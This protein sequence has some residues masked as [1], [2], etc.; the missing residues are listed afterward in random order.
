LP[1]YGES[2]PSVSLTDLV[3]LTLQASIVL[4][5]FGLGLR[6]THQDVTCLFRRPGMLARSLLPMFVVMPIL[7]AL[8]AGMFGLRPPVKIALVALSVSPVPPL[9]PRRTMRAGGEPSYTFGLLVAA[10]LLSIVLL[11]VEL[12]S[13]GLAFGVPL[14]APAAAMIK[15]VSVTVIAPLGGGILARSLAPQL[16]ARIAK[17]ILLVAMVML[18]GGMIPVLLKAGPAIVSLVGNGTLAAIAAFIVAG[19]IAGHLLG[20]PAPEHRTVLALATAFRHPGIAVAIAESNFP[21]QKLV[22]AAVLL[23]LLVGAVLA[24]PYVASRRR[25][26]GRQINSRIVA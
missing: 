21:E 9:L 4:N 13:I 16:V 5:V 17:P 6:A 20:G 19:L 3:Q 11:P 26:A 23:Y 8:I 7:A 10:A 24:F 2:F 1:P 22:L 14:R 18:A 12:E 25:N 15:L